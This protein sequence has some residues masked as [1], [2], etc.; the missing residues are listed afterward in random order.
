MTFIFKPFKK[1]CLHLSSTYLVKFGAINSVIIDSEDSCK[2]YWLLIGRYSCEYTNS[3]FSTPASPIRNSLQISSV[4]SSH[5]C[6]I[7]L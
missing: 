6:I 3:A 1:L 7:C 5:I 2:D 4:P